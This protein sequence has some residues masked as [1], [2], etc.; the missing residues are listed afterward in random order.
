MRASSYHFS[1]HHNR[2]I[3]SHLVTKANQIG[4]NMHP[5]R[6][7][8]FFLVIVDH[9]NR[10]FT[11]EG[12]MSNDDPWNAAVIAK[13]ESGRDVRCFLGKGGPAQIIESYTRSQ[14][15]TNVERGSILD[16]R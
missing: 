9:D 5:S 8:E 2:G 1:R 14:G 3:D 7:K 4:V 11:V 10:I 16:P 12:P 6:R 13:Q 15:Y